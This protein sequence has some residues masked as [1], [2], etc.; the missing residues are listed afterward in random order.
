MFLVHSLTHTIFPIA[1]ECISI[2]SAL[3]C[4][5]F[6]TCSK[7]SNNKTFRLMPREQERLI[8]FT[9]KIL[10]RR[11]STKES[12]RRVWVDPFCVCLSKHAQ[13]YKYVWERE[14]VID[15]SFIAASCYGKVRVRVRVF[16]SLSERATCSAHR[17]GNHENLLLLA[18][19]RCAC[20]CVCTWLRAWVSSR[21]RHIVLGGWSAL[22]GHC[23]NLPLP[24]QGWLSRAGI[25]QFGILCA[26]LSI[27]VY[28]CLFCYS[29]CP[30]FVAVNMNIDFSYLGP[31]ALPLTH[32]LPLSFS[33]CCV[34]SALSLSSGN[35]V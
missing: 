2:L 17:G 16:C 24:A 22:W 30:V 6:S 20:V 4:L 10:D 14:I 12:N 25:Q 7:R 29:F 26:S 15:V 27:V 21:R 19:C 34:L 13:A 33:L 35:W 5:V 32:T 18:D 1:C 28:P 11:L 31:S 9:A 3:P 8:E 23:T